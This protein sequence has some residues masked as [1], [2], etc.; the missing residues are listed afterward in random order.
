MYIKNSFSHENKIF[1]SWDVPENLANKLQKSF[2]IPDDIIESAMS[3]SFI[4]DEFNS[5]IFDE[6]IKDWL[7]TIYKH[8]IYYFYYYEPTPI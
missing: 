4:N 1:V 2:S 3:H 5:D 7:F 8:S 6:K